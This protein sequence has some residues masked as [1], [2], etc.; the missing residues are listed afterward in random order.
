MRACMRGRAVG[1]ALAVLVLGGCAGGG[2]GAATP[3]ATAWSFGAAEH[4][5]LWYH[6]LALA[7]HAVRDELPAA[8]PLP[9]YRDGYAD[10]ILA[11]KTAAGV[12]PTRLD[13]LAGEFGRAFV[14]QTAYD[15]IEFLPLYFLDSSALFAAV[16]VWQQAGGEPRNART[17][18]AQQ[19][20]AFLSQLFPATE[21]R[22]L[23]GRWAEVLEEEARVFFRGHWERQFLRLR[24]TARD[25]DAEWRPIAAGLRRILESY[26]LEGGEAFLVPALGAEGR[27]VARGAGFPRVAVQAPA[28][29]APRETVYA[30]IHELLY[31]MIGDLVRQH[32]AAADPSGPD[33]RRLGVYAAVRG[34]AMLLESAAPA[35][36]PEYRRYYLREAGHDAGGDAPAFEAAFPLPGGLHDALRDML[37]RGRSGI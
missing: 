7:Q 32:A 36:L 8:L 35:L 31:P 6:G 21:Q 29:A 10:S 2:P 11:A 1:A 13:S 24:Q 18:D 19:A 20:T 33:E 5:A 3:R 16:R 25:V 28:A 26:D 9:H 12:G 14:G 4:I 30:F 15:A 17:P 27:I 34:G 23:V 37:E 22:Q